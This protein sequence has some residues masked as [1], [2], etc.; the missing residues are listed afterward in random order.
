MIISPAPSIASR[1]LTARLRIAFSSWFGSAQTCQSSA[2]KRVWTVIR[3]PIARSTS[4]SMFSTSS[5]GA[6]ASGSSGSAR[7]K[8]SRRRVRA[9]ARVAPSIALSRWNSTSRRGAVQLAPGE[10]EAADDD[11]EHVVEIVGD[12]AGQLADRLH[13]LDLAQ[14]RLGGGALGGLG[15][16]RAHWRR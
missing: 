6:T 4:S 2:A 3:S 14:L 10:I 7:A 16:Q 12:A 5:A 8:A 13:L 9:A 15:L 1:A 11:R